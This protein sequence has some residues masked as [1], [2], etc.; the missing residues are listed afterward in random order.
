M[1]SILVLGHTGILGSALYAAFLKHQG[2]HVL[3]YSKSKTSISSSSCSTAFTLQQLLY[4]YQPNV[5]INCVGEYKNRHLFVKTNT[6]FIFHLLTSISDVYSRENLPTLFH[7]SSIGVLCPYRSDFSLTN[8]NQYESSKFLSERLIR[9]YS[10]YSP[11]KITIFRPS[12]ILSSKSHFLLRLFFIFLLSPANLTSK[13]RIIPCISLSRLTR[14][15]FISVLASLS[16]DPSPSIS[17]C[18]L[19]RPYSLYFFHRF[20]KRYSHLYRCFSFIKCS[21]PFYNYLPHRFLQSI[22]CKPF[23]ISFERYN[24]FLSQ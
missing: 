1:I 11:E 23:S 16:V 20:F 5:I 21:F 13:S 2:I 6:D 9:V 3:G 15:I 14:G 10:L 17:T 7:V 22:P 12:T 24:E 4:R 18:L 8:L 19:S